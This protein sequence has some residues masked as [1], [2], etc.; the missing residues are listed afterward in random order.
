MDKTPKRNRKATYHDECR[1]ISQKFKMKEGRK[2]GNLQRKKENNPK[3]TFLS[4]S[5]LSY[6]NSQKNPF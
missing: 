5:G 4:Q 2:K 6:V 3:K 1:L